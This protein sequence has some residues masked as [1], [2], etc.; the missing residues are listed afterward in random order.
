MLA[1]ISEGAEIAYLGMYEVLRT[2]DSG[3]KYNQ[4]VS[5]EHALVRLGEEGQAVLHR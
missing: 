2:K 1:V 4:E 5:K 3:R